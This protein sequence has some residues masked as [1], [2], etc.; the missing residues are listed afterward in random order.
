LSVMLYTS[1]GLHTL[2]RSRTHP[3]ACVML[4]SV[5]QQLAVQHALA[6]ITSG[7]CFTSDERTFTMI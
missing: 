5:T 1:W 6:A 7:S 3:Y 2:L 4:V